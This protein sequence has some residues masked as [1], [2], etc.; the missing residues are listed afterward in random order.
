M[1][2]VRTHVLLLVA[3]LA[4]ASAIAGFGLPPEFTSEPVLDGL[5]SPTGFRFAPDGRMFVCER[6]EGRLR[7][8][9]LDEETGDWTL[10]AEP[11]HVFDVPRD[12]DG[13][14]FPLRPS[15]LRDVAFD[16]DFAASGYVYAFYMHD[17]ARQN[18]VVRLTTDPT[19]PDRALPESEVLLLELPV[20]DG[21]ASGSHNGG[22]LASGPDG[23]LYATTGDGWDGG[24]PVQSLDTFTGKLVRIAPDG[25]IPGDNPFHADATGDLRAIYALGLRNPFTMSAHPV[26]GA[27]YVNDVVSGAKA[28]VLVATAGANYGH[29]GYGGIGV[30]TDEWVDAGD[31]GGK[32][33]SGGAW[34]PSASTWPTAYDGGYFVAMWGPNSATPGYVHHVDPSGPSVQGFATDVGV[35][36]GGTGAMLKPVT[37]AFGPDGHLYLALTTYQTAEGAIHRIR[38]DG[39][40]DADAV[41]PTPTIALTPAPNPA[42]A[43]TRITYALPGAGRVALTVIDVEG[44]EVARLAEGARPAG[45]HAITLDTSSYE[46]GVYHV[47]LEAGSVERMRKLVVI[48]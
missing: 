26:T 42:R 23:Y 2:G 18:R 24:D 11:F 20:N 30:D 12:G 6:I 44:R 46:P 7:V 9:H 37:P 40:L 13:D 1:I 33:I 31:A 15:G 10:L 48:R 3:A 19:D 29:Q 22:A 43:S 28:N 5:D 39:V 25:S 8:A 45:T 14:P 34:L 4:P 35:T 47:R 32:V 17:G 38:W 16:P 21:D 41:P 27:L 36:D